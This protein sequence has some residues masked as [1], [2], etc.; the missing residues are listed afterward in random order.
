MAPLL[1]VDRSGVNYP[2]WLRGSEAANAQNI[3]AEFYSADVDYR[4]TRRAPIN[5]LPMPRVKDSLKELFHG[6]CAYCES[7][8]RGQ[9]GELDHFRPKSAAS[10]LKGDKQYSDHYGWFFYE[11]KNHFLACVSCNRSK[12]NL[13][14]VDGPRAPV[15]SSWEEACGSES[16]FL[17]DPCLDFPER[18]L[19]FDHAGRVFSRTKRGQATI[20]VL[21]LNRSDLVDARREKFQRC[22]DML[23]ALRQGS[24]NISVILMRE[25]EGASAYSGATRILLYQTYRKYLQAEGRR[26][27]SFNSFFGREMWRDTKLFDETNILDALEQHANLVSKRDSFVSDSEQ[28]VVPSLKSA[29]AFKDFRSSSAVAMIRRVE[30]R[31][32]KDVEHL[33]LTF[34]TSEGEKELGCAMLIGENSVGKSSVLQAIA[35]CLMGADLRD[36]LKINAEDFISREIEGW[37][38]TR[39]KDAKIKV[40]FTSGDVSELVIP[41]AGPSFQGGEEPS[42]VVLGYGARRYFD[43][44]RKQSATHFGLR[45]L[46]EPSA[47][48]SHPERWLQRQPEESF[49][50]IARAMRGILLLQPDDEIQRDEDGRIYVAAHQRLTPIDRLSDG[51]K[52][53]F[54]MAVDI[55]REMVS[56]W[57]N[58]EYARGVV[59]IDEIET[60]LHPRWKMQ[61]VTALRRAMPQVQFIC[62]TH[63]PLCLRGMRDEEVTVLFR[64]DDKVIQSL[65]DLP[66]LSSLRAEQLLTSDYFGLVSTSDPLAEAELEEYALLSSG[67]DLTP[68]RQA[69]LDELTNSTGTLTIIGDTPAQQI[70]S[71]AYREYLIERG[72]ADAAKRG[73]L[74]RDAVEDVLMALRAR[75]SNA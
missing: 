12:R 4:S 44:R 13:F 7:D 35:L 46:F 11:W 39:T 65:D 52:S 28:L 15:L 53:L 19:R 16:A 3:L 71:E 2:E 27:P 64:D 33:D 25:L 45:T 40:F 36:M 75:S 74:R 34:K 69:R 72:A 29:G 32:F 6:K 68:D 30:I 20:D 23:E 8:L 43:G 26:S 50:A 21:N 61:V 18:H 10:N 57:G 9:G 62:T 14:P 56:V 48:I 1:K 38:H 42:G 58:L 59:L 60:H 5:E 70:V 31:N 55:M 22:G 73:A 49:N 47:T 63:D 51:Y 41:C 37:R 66:K 54:A 24:E 67:S 17:L